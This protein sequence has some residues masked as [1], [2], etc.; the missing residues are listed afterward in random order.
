MTVMRE[1]PEVQS[2]KTAVTG[3]RVRLKVAVGAGA[4]L[5]ASMVASPF[6]VAAV[7]HGAMTA[8]HSARVGSSRNV[9]ASLMVTDSR[10]GTRAALVVASK[11]PALWPHWGTPKGPLV[12]S[13][14]PPAVWP[15]W[16][17][18]KGPLVAS[19]SPAL[20]PHWGTPKGPLVASKS[21][22]AVWP[23]WGTPKGPL[24]ASKS[25]PAVWPHWGHPK[26]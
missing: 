19:K 21:P 25:P 17:T 16:G 26:A 22:P 9:L 13:K 14:S 8:S 24:V 15:H 10:Q 11:S 1:D 3:F 4:V 20:W 23:H 18:P 5:V 7:P 2:R 6:A 12:A